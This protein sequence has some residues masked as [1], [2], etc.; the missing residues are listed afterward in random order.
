MPQCK[1]VDGLY[2]DYCVPFCSLHLYRGVL[3]LEKVQRGTAVMTKG[4]G[5]TERTCS[6]EQNGHDNRDWVHFLFHLKNEWSSSE[7]TRSQETKK[8]RWFFTWRVF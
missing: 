5:V 3:V 7:A 8:R 1:S 4:V 2:V 6:P